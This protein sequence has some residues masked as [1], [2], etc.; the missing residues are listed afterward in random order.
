MEIGDRLRKWEKIRDFETIAIKQMDS[1]CS[2][3]KRYSYVFH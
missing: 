1:L 2:N 3:V